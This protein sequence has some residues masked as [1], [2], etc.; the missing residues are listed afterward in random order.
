MLEKVKAS[1]DRFLSTRNFPAPMTNKTRFIAARV[2][3]DTEKGVSS[4]AS[5][6]P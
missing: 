4:I 6:P 2:E 3:A 5:P 1:D